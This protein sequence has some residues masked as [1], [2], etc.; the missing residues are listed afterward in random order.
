MEVLTNCELFY[1]KLNGTCLPQLFKFIFRL[2]IES[3]W[4]FVLWIRNWRR[5]H[6]PKKKNPV[7]NLALTS[8]II[9]CK[10]NPFFREKKFL[11]QLSHS[12]A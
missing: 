4:P 2:R 11:I 1:P 10:V 12:A 9:L 7:Q 5:K 6:N 3:S 8:V